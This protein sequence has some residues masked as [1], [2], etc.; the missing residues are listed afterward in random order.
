M[1]CSNTV[2][3][4][5]STLGGALPI[6]TPSPIRQLPSPRVK[7]AELA[8]LCTSGIRSKY[9]TVCNECIGHA[10]MMKTSV[11]LTERV[12]SCNPVLNSPPLPA[13]A[14]RMSAMNSGK[15]LKQ[16]ARSEWRPSFSSFSDRPARRDMNSSH[17]CWQRE[18]LACADSA[19]NVCLLIDF[20]ISALMEESVVVKRVARGAMRVA[21]VDSSAG[22]CGSGAS[23]SNNAYSAY[24]EDQSRTVETNV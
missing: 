16:D 8:A 23:S 5:V 13:A 4:S 9:L 7:R 21:N 20:L 24:K 2:V 6:C 17:R 11:G 18:R 15:L 3:S 19:R 14:R 10:A 22:P 1:K 12:M